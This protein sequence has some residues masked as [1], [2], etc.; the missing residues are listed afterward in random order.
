MSPLATF[1]DLV[2]AL[3]LAFP[4]CEIE[5]SPVFLDDAQKGRIEQR[6]GVEAPSV[7]FRYLARRDGRLVGC[8]YVDSHRVRTLR[9]TLLLV[10]T[11]EGTLRSVEVIAFAEPKEYL[12][13]PRFYDQFADQKLDDD[14]DLGRGIDGVTGATLTT[15][16]TTRAARRTLAAHQELLPALRESEAARWPASLVQAAE[17]ARALAGPDVEGLHPRAILWD[18]ERL[19]RLPERKGIVAGF[20]CQHGQRWAYAE[21]SLLAGRPAAW[22]FCFDGDRL[23]S[24]KRLCGE[25]APAQALAA[26]EQDARQRVTA[27]HT[28]RK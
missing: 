26:A 6:S 23:Q 12:P 9:E 28:T 15:R 18:E 8:A 22:L 25:G 7:L 14:L 10:V 3:L 5:R 13:R 27:L 19:R 16:A 17:A 2:T 21:T 20:A 1:S 11:P 24:S 4:G